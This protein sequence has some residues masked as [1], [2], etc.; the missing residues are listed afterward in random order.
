MLRH[1][2]CCLRISITFFFKADHKVVLLLVVYSITALGVHIGEEVQQLKCLL[3]FLGNDAGRGC[4][5]W[6]M[7]LYI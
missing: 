6:E 5:D 1:F 4:L 3:G 7:V 2:R